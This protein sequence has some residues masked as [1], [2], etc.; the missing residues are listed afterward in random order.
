MTSPTNPP[1]AGTR[2]GE[3]PAADTP[4]SAVADHVAA[5]SRDAAVLARQE[6]DAVRAELTA[7]ARKVLESGALLGGAGLAGALALTTSG[8]LIV[9]VLD[10][11]LPE[12]LSAAVATAGLGFAAVTLGRQGVTHVKS[13]LAEPASG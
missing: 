5:L 7:S 6:F 9:R 12:G 3:P 1:T 11:F 2:D 8:V 4:A 10:W 13:A